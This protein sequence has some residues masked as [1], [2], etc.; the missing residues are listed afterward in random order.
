VLPVRED[1]LEEPGFFDLMENL[2][3]H[4]GAAQKFMTGLSE[5]LD[6][7]TREMNASGDLMAEISSVRNISAAEG[8]DLVNPVADE[9]NIYSKYIESE[10]PNYSEGMTLMFDDVRGLIDVSYDFLTS[11]NTEEQIV[12]IEDLR[13]SLVEMRLGM[14]GLKS[15]QEIY[16]INLTKLQRMT[17]LFNRAKKR[18]LHNVRLLD[19]IVGS[20]IDIVD[21]AIGEIDKFIDSARK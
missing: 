18:L 15:S 4:A 21:Q 8:K 16:I 5:R 10:L 20:H 1:D 13:S 2:E 19:G 9:M 3:S 14:V 11:E 17:G 6:S 12:N 7:L